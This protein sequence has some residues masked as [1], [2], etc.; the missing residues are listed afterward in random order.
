MN[1]VQIDKEF[2]AEDIANAIVNQVKAEIKSKFGNKKRHK[3]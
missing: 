1:K 3:Q 2:N